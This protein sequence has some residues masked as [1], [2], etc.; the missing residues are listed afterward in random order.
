MWKS[1]DACVLNL[2]IK[3]LV[4]NGCS[5]LVIVIQQLLLL[6]IPIT[7][8]AWCLLIYHVLF[9]FTGVYREVRSIR[10]ERNVESSTESNPKSTSY[11]LIGFKSLDKQFSQVS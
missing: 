11:I 7:K 9:G 4:I 2:G 5:W 6:Y 3:V 1:R 8:L 10:P